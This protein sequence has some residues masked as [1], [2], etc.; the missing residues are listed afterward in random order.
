MLKGKKKKLRLVLTLLPSSYC[1]GTFRK[2]SEV[3]K[4][5]CVGRIVGANK[6]PNALP[7]AP[8]SK[9]YMVEMKLWQGLHL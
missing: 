5:K 3:Q 7:V 2:D 8:A 1:N 4:A 9:L 6:F